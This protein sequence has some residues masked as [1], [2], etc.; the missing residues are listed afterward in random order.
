MSKSLINNTNSDDLGVTHQA[1]GGSVVQTQ[2]DSDTA[3]YEETFVPWFCED[4][5]VTSDRTKENNPFFF[6]ESTTLIPSHSPL[7]SRPQR[8]SKI[9][10]KFNDYIIEGKY[11]YG[12]KKIS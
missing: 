4:V 10:T 1:D 12:V 2:I 9:P 6:S 3:Y 7:S 11:K 8:V 5:P